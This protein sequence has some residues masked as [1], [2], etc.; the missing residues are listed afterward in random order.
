LR[1]TKDRGPIVLLPNQLSRKK[2]KAQDVQVVIII[3]INS[4]WY[5]VL[6]PDHLRRSER[7]RTIVGAP[8]NVGLYAAARTAEP[9][10]IPIPVKVYELKYRGFPGLILVD[11]PER[12]EL[13]LNNYAR[14]EEDRTSNMFH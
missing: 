12:A 11:D 8:E 10:Q 1:G 4:K 7:T 5:K 13:S 9:I 14:E 3:E 2:G 6:L